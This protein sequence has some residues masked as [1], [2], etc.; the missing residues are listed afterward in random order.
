MLTHMDI[1]QVTA[2]NLQN[3]LNAG[4]AAAA[5]ES[6]TPE[7]QWYPCGFAWLNIRMRKNHRLSRILIENG[8]RW[9]DYRKSYTF[10]LPMSMH[11][12]NMSQAM[13]YKERVLQKMRDVLLDY[14]VPSYVSTHID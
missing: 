3:A 1:N 14:G 9:D 5:E 7:P 6:K 10:S 2:T 8:W 11:A 4:L 12:P 13:D